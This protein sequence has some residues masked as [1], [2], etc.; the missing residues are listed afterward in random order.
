MPETRMLMKKVAEPQ[1]LA[2][3]VENGVLAYANITYG[4]PPVSWL[5]VLMS[6]TATGLLTEHPAGKPV[7]A[8]W[9]SL[10]VPAVPGFPPPPVRGAAGSKTR[11]VVVWL[12]FKSVALSRM[13]DPAHVKAGYGGFVQAFPPKEKILSPAMRSGGTPLSFIGWGV[14]HEVPDPYH[15][16]IVT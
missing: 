1:T 4:V 11:S 15:A 10:T 12:P 7:R 6:K 9:K 2:E 13:M 14:A 5:K 16:V 3:P 8:Y